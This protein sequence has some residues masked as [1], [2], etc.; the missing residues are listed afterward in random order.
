MFGDRNRMKEHIAAVCRLIRDNGFQDVLDAFNAGLQ[1]AFAG[2]Q[3]AENVLENAQ[4]V[5]SQVLNK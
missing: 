3:T 2:N 5:G 4:D 1:D